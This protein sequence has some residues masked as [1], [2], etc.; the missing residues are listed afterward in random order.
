[1]FSGHDPQYE[2]KHDGSGEAYARII[3]LRRDK[4]LNFLEVSDW[5]WVRTMISIQYEMLLEKGIDELGKTTG[6]L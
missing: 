6:R 1:M 4:I 3:Y 2:L 5:D